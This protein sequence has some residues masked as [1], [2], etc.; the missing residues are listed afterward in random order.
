MWALA[1]GL[2]NINWLCGRWSSMGSE[3]CPVSVRPPG[4]INTCKTN[5]LIACVALLSKWRYTT[6]EGSECRLDGLLHWH[7]I[8][9]DLHTHFCTAVPVHTRAFSNLRVQ[10]KL[11]V[12][13]TLY[14]L[15]PVSESTKELCDNICCHYLHE[16]HLPVLE[17]LCQVLPPCQDLTAHCMLQNR[18]PLPTLT[19][20]V[21]T[22]PS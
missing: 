16:I 3:V 2:L 8:N 18:L 11:C 17:V 14:T 15:S 20:A 12:F 19:V 13:V 10:N 6:R 7:C 9:T 21:D 5:N 1:E 4:P 22:G